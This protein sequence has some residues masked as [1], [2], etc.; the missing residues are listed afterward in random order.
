MTLEEQIL[1]LEQQ[2]REEMRN[3]TFLWARAK[4][5]IQRKLSPDRMVRKHIGVSLVAAAVGAMLLAPAPRRQKSADGDG[6]SKLKWLGAIKGFLPA[7]LKH[8]MGGNGSAEHS[9]AAAR[10]APK[11]R[12]GLTELL[13]AELLSLAAQRINWSGL[14]Q[15]LMAKFADRGAAA[16]HDEAS[17]AVGDV[18]TVPAD[19]PFDGR[20][21]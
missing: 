7:R 9:E 3:A 5:D 20:T 12:K 15:Q 21:N 8:F 10:V 16:G 14:L 2:Q 1:E 11:S 18:G 4:R 6:V 17:A 19:R 13:V